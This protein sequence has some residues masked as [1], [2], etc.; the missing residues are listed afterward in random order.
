MVF[1]FPLLDVNKHH[2]KERGGG[3]K[4]ML[5]LTMGVLASC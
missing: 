3:G 5:K 2:G 1:I 4:G